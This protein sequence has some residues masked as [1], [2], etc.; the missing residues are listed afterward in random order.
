ML[1]HGQFASNR[2]TLPVPSE[3]TLYQQGAG[4]T[5]LVACGTL[6]PAPGKV[7]DAFDTCYTWVEP[8]T[9]A[10][11]SLVFTL[12]GRLSFESGVLSLGRC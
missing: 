11:S 9:M 2:V 5:L 4:P 1:R 3:L 7:I 10:F 8:S 6:R 12:P